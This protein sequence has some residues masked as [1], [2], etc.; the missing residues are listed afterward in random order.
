MKADIFIWN[1][2]PG[3]L[4]RAGFGSAVL[5]NKYPRLITCDIIGYGNNLGFAK[6]KSHDIP[7]QAESGLISISGGENELGRVGISI[8]DANAG[9]NAHV[10][11]PEAPILRDKTGA[12]N[13]VEVSLFGTAADWMTGP[14]LHYDY[15]GK[16]PIRTGIHH[17]S[18]A[19]YGGCF[20]KAGE[21]VIIVAQNEWEWVRF[22]EIVLSNADYAADSR[23]DSNRNQVTNRVRLDEL[24]HSITLTL[25][26]QEFIDRLLDEEIAYGTVNNVENLSQHP[27]LHQRTGISSTGEIVEFPAGAISYIGQSDSEEEPLRVPYLGKHTEQIQTEF[28]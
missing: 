2:S 6:L 4:H 10:G 16:T 7:V 1:L 8:C 13:G 21:S 11:V 20:T 17:P 12:E 25:T 26:K 14:L 22:C 24:I 23:F 3:A 5:R 18:I 9:M 27:A 28:A 19:L 15:G